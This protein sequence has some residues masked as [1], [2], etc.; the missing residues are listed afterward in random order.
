MPALP[1]ARL[2]SCTSTC[3]RSGALRRLGLGASCAATSRWT[4]LPDKEWGE[5]Q[6]DCCQQFDE[7][8]QGGAGGVLEWIAD[9][10]ADD[11]RRV[12]VRLLAEHRTGRVEQVARLDVLLGVV[13]G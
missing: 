11:R 6:G 12:G 8:V 3:T 13:P 9:R 1:R 7:D 5:H 2:R 4:L 10:V